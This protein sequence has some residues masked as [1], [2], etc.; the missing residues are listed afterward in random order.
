[1]IISGSGEDYPVALIFPNNK[2]IKDPDYHIS[3][4]EGCFYPKSLNEFGHCL[5]GCL[6]AANRDIKQKFSKIKLAAV[7]DSELSLEDRTLTPSMKVAPRNVLEKYKNHLANMYGE[8]VPTEE[9]VYIVE[10][11]V[12]N[13]IA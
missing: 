10:L 7:I 3:E 11:D 4:V 13:Q 6:Q 8:K 12:K 9:E 1:V 5:H 2:M